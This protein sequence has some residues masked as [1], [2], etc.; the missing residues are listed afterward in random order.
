MPGTTRHPVPGVRSV[1]LRRVSRTWPGPAASFRPDVEGLRAVAVL[2]VVVSH[3]LGTPSGGY[4]GVDVFFVISGFL[5]TGLLL[6]EHGRRGRISLRDFYARRVRRLLPAAVLVLA[7][8]NVAAY[9]LFA[10]ER[11]G[12]ALRDS[13]WALGFLANVRFASIGTDYFDDTRPPSPV[14]HYWSLA[15]E[16]QFYVV[17]PL[18]LIFA[19]F[20]ARRR[21]A[22]VVLVLVTAASLAWSVSATA[23]DA[24][25]AYFSTPARAWE[26]GIGALIAFGAAAGLAQRLPVRVAVALGW[27]GLGGIVASAFLLTETTPFPGTAAL[28]PVLSTAVVLV[29]GEAGAADRNPLLVN[30][31]SSYLGRI[32]YSLYLWHWP[33]LILSVAVLPETLHVVVPLAGALVLAALSHHLVEEPVRHSSWLSR[34]PA[35]RTLP[36]GSGRR[37]AVATSAAVALLGGG[38]V[39]PAVALHRDSL[40]PPVAGERPVPSPLPSAQADPDL[41]Q[42]RIAASLEPETWPPLDPPLDGL[43][44]AGAPEWIEDKCDNVNEGNLSDCRYGPADAPRT[45]VLFGDS[46]AISWLPALREV[47]EP[48]GFSIQ[49]LTRNQCPAPDVMFYRERPEEPFTNCAVHKQWALEQVQRLQ[50]E[51]VLVSNSLSLVGKQVAQP[52]GDEQYERWEEG[53]AD[54]LAALDDAAGRVVLLGAPPR[55][56]NLQACVTRLSDPSDCTEPV[57]DEWRAVSAAERAAA[58][59][60]GADYVDP[61]PWFCAEG[62]CPAVVGAT[63]VYT[64]GRHLTSAYARQLAPY[65]ARELE[66]SP[67]A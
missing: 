45:A 39:L 51:L 65:L 33:V 18:L 59:T 2:L 23:S 42:E 47:L 49:V 54:T 61:E 66:V 17:W 44:F 32:S 67:R 15:V 21:G 53:M 62:R 25:S 1:P 36:K 41:L 40:P 27:L 19:L 31:L 50:P 22:L 3:V 14:Q 58:Q 35:P 6:R 24:T 7:V 37:A 55:S 30:P 34:R 64:D 60:V 11:A 46:M 12:Q 48:A 8:T 63:P 10:G 4:V 13:V 28:L 5:I 52:S 16:E 43:R 56:G 57:P 9:L 29:A 20:V 38:F 26:L